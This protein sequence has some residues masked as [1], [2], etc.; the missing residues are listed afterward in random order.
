[1]IIAASLWYL[2]IFSADGG[3][4]S[5]PS[6]YESED[7]CEAAIVELRVA[8]AANDFDFQCMGPDED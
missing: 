3:L 6:S 7:E 8:S 2:L 5:T 1:M 4:V